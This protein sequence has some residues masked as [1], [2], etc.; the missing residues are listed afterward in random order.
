MA[1]RSRERDLCH[2]IV[3]VIRWLTI[4]CVRSACHRGRCSAKWDM[5]GR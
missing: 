1:C 3:D 5:V 4:R 2:R